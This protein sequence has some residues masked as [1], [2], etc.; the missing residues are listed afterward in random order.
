MAIYYLNASKGSR[1][2]GQSAAAKFQ[3]ITRSG[4]YAAGHAEIVTTMSGN[5]PCWAGGPAAFWAAADQHERAN[6]RL[7]RSYVI[8]LPRELGPPEWEALAKSLASQICGKDRLPWSAAIHAGDG[9][10]P[11]LH[12][13]INERVD[14]GIARDGPGWFRRAALAGDDP[15]SGGARKTQRL[16]RP[17][18]TTPRP[19]WT[20][21]PCTSPA[22]R[23][24]SRMPIP[25]SG[26]APCRAGA[27]A[28]AVRPPPAPAAGRGRPGAAMTSTGGSRKRPGSRR[29]GWRRGRPS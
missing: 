28:A 25:T 13:V 16:R 3:Y 23:L 18:I 4:R 11:H 21:C 17:V 12:L 29:S 27:A 10:N 6:G 1:S 7:F 24:P 26:P 9:A 8:S 19:N 2:T 5:L 15:A 14:D 20:G 22:P